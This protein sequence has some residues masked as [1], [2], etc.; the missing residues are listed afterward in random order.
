MSPIFPEMLLI[1]FEEKK[2]ISFVE[3]N[4]VKAIYYYSLEM[5]QDI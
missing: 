3:I 2:C 4:E 5:L 1:R